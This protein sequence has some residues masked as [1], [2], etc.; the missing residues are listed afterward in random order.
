MAAARL[1]RMVRRLL[2]V[3]A[4]MAGR[5]AEPARLTVARV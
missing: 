4:A 5:A 1:A 3:V 2:T